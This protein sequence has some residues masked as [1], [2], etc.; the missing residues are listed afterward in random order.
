[1]AHPRLSRQPEPDFHGQD[2]AGLGVGVAVVGHMVAVLAGYLAAGWELQRAGGP[3]T[4]LDAGDRFGVNA[5]GLAAFGVAEAAVLGICLATGLTALA[6]NRTR[7]GGGV[8]AGWMVGLVLMG[9]CG[10]LQ[11]IG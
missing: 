8:L 2:P 5:M 7:F 3:E 10:A 6:R 11:F 9:I 1:M 4:D